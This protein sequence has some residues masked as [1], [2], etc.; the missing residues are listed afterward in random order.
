MWQSR[1]ATSCFS[2]SLFLYGYLGSVAELCSLL[3]IITFCLT[4]TKWCNALNEKQTKAYKQN[5]ANQNKNIREFQKLLLVVTF[6]TFFST[7]FF[8]TGFQSLLTVFAVVATI[9]LVGSS[10]ILAHLV[11]SWLTGCRSLYL[12]SSLLVSSE[13]KGETYSTIKGLD[14]ELSEPARESCLTWQSSSYFSGRI[15]FWLLI[16]KSYCLR[17]KYDGNY[18]NWWKT[19]QRDLF[20]LRDLFAKTSGQHLVNIL[21]IIS[22]WFFLLTSPCFHNNA[23]LF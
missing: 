7:L 19:P 23:A 6:Q 9:V 3:R 13:V 18:D 16:N 2:S 20:V 17:C 15:I 14:F 12:C 10:P 5:K 1:R 21:Q 22:C 8:N 11:W 4:F